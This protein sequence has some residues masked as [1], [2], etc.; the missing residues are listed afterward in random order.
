[1]P[2]W[3]LVAVLCLLRAPQVCPLSRAEGPAV[4]PWGLRWGLGALG[5]HPGGAQD[6]APSLGPFRRVCSPRLGDTASLG[7]SRAR[8][9]PEMWQ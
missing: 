5:S 8:R 2:A 1:M 9:A 6:P 4:P 7:C 3:G